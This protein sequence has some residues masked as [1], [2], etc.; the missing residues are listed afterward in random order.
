M[1]REELLREVVEAFCLTGGT[2]TRDDACRATK[3]LDEFESRI[4]KLYPKQFT[5]KL[6][7]DK[8]DREWQRNLTILRQLLQYHGHKLLSTRRCYWDRK[9]KRSGHL[10]EYRIL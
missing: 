1:E 9:L 7:E 5:K 4:L 6:R 10:Y 2:I 8:S 3:K